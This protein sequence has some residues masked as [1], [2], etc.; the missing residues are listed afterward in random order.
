MC[1]GDFVGFE[2]PTYGGVGKVFRR[3][4]RFIR[5][6]QC[7]LKT[8]Q[9]FDHGRPFDDAFVVVHKPAE[10][11]LHVGKRAAG[12]HHVAEAHA[13]GEVHRQGGDDGDKHGKA[14]IGGGETFQIKLAP[15]QAAPVAFDGGKT[16]VQTA[17]FGGFA[18]V[19]GDLL[20]RLAHAQ[21]RGAVV[22]LAVLAFHIQGLE[23]AAD[24]VGEQGAGGGVG[25][26]DP[27]EI[28]FHRDA[29]PEQGEGL[30]AGEL[31][32]D[33]DKRAEFGGVH[34]EIFEEVDAFFRQHGDVFGDA[35][36]GVVR[37]ARELQAVVFVA[38]E[39]VLL[40]LPRKVFAPAEQQNLA[41]PVAAGDKAGNE[42]DID[43]KFRYQHGHGASV[44]RGQRV[45]KGFVPV[46]N[47]HAHAHDGERKADYGGQ[48][49]PVEPGVVAPP[50]RRGEGEET[51]DGFHRRIGERGESGCGTD[52]KG[53]RPSENRFSDGLFAAG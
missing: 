5:L 43:E 2:N 25:Q 10:A 22:G 13:V 39:P 45:V 48:Q 3:P 40:E 47:Q 34:D 14:Q 53:K 24:E 26:R 12:F 29:L 30:H 27:H 44:E 46:S 41:Q 23:F 49:Q 42:G 7:R 35:L 51:A 36:V 21:Q 16:A 31:P 17:F 8:G 18:T 9:T 4:C 19:K 33:F 28:A 6:V 11:V 15:Y 1:G 50:K 37:L 32:Q 52:A 38:A 20:G